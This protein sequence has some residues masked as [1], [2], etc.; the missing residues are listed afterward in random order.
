MASQLLV[1]LLILLGHLLVIG[2]S[3]PS[4]LDPLTTYMFRIAAVNSDGVGPYSDTE[5]LD[6]IFPTGS[7]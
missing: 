2:T 1:L 4:G 6:T 7:P 5:S 3:L